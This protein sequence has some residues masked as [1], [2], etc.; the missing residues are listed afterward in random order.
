[1]AVHITHCSIA[2]NFPYNIRTC[3]AMGII[4][5]Q[6]YYIRNT[7]QLRIIRTT[8]NHVLTWRKNDGRDR[9]LSSIECEC[10][11]RKLQRDQYDCVKC[12]SYRF[13]L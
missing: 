7:H 12:Y 13:Y 8:Y 6:E 5:M 11:Q 1:M 2:N 10:A 4:E 9:F 3:N